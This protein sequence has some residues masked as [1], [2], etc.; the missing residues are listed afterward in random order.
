MG[1]DIVRLE[2]QHHGRSGAWMSAPPAHGLGLALEG[3]ACNLLLQWHLG[4][5]VVGTDVAGRPCPTCGGAVDPFG[6]HSVSCGRA[7]FGKRHLG[8]Q[9]FLCRALSCAR[10]PHDREVAVTGE[11]SRLADILLKE[12]VAGKD[13]AVDLTLVH[14][15][16]VSAPRPAAGSAAA[17]FAQS[18]RAKC[19]A[20]EGR[21]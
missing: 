2:A 17:F 3:G 19:S 8:I 10:V 13:L 14:P 21:G 16:A 9:Q 20:S 1:R 18:A 15:A 7:A 6:D 5:P 4:L 12:W 11:L